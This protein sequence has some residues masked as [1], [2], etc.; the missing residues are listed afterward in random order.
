MTPGMGALSDSAHV[1]A[2]A[3]QSMPMT[4]L[5]LLRRSSATSL[6]A[7]SQPVPLSGLSPQ[8]QK[9]SAS[10]GQTRSLPVSH[11]GGMR[12]NSST[13]VATQLHVPFAGLEPEKT[14]VV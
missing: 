12:R 6:V 11:L 9:S 4:R 10:L 5:G 7:Q 2:L 3:V 13:P 8:K 1:P 14:D